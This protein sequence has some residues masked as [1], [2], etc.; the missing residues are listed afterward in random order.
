[1]SVF[2]IAEAGVNHNGDIE[3]AHRLIDAAA[4]AG[5]D[6][7]K[8]QTFRAA[9][10]A[11]RDA[12]KAAYQERATGAAESQLDMLR[13]LELAPAAHF[14]LRDHAAKR[15]VAFLSTPFDSA[16]LDFLTGEMGME[17]IKIP[18]GEI[19]NGPFLLRIARAA[20]RIV[21]STGMSSLGE[22][23]AAL[24]VLAFGLSATP[25]TAPSHA[26]FEAA[27]LSQAGQAALRARV[28]LLH[29]T[30]EYPAAAADVNLRAMDTMAAAFGLAVGYSDHTQGIHIPVAAAAR[31]AVLIEKHFTLDRS[32]PGPDHKAS[33]EPEELA[34]MV[35]AIREVEA[36]L[37]DGVKRPVAA[38]I[39]NRAVVRKSLVAARPIA[40]G[41]TLSAETLACKRPGTGISPMDFWALCGRPA[42]RAY[43]EGEAIDP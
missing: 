5:A 1:M 41:E 7:V 17:T 42:A 11:G 36:A 16:S 22:V 33:L 13:R 2:V 20:Q 6:A 4:D 37:G 25:D 38:E 10:L 15:E 18:S 29:C 40:A 28:T 14:A 21:L 24:A 32:L 9:D 8:F 34:A 19:T 27:F 30:T 31:G 23:E 43:A 26:A 39:G 3:M 35:R 12:P